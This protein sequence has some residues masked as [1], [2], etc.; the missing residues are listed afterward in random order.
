MVSFE[1]FGFVL[2]IRESSS[3]LTLVQEKLMTT[4]LS[5]FDK[6]KPPKKIMKRKGKNSINL[7][8]K[9]KKKGLKW[10]K[11]DAT[12]IAIVHLAQ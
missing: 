6:S 1:A 2:R 7:T 9:W 4:V 3:K 11:I 5:H 8:V 10:N 12:V